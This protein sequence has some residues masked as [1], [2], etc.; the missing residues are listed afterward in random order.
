M[1]GTAGEGGL[2]AAAQRLAT[3]VLASGRT[4][5][6]LLGNELQFEKQ[7]IIR[8]AVLAQALALCAGIGTVIA[9]ALLA[10][11]FWEQRFAVLGAGALVFLGAAAFFYSALQR[12]IDEKKP[13]FDD[14]VAELEEDLRQLTAALRDAEAAEKAAKRGADGAQQ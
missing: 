2:L 5:L 7:R 6:E 8:I 14:S 9:F 4:R 12:A 3:T 1:D 11:L 13:I 10:L